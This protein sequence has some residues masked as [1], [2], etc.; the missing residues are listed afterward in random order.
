MKKIA[1]NLKTA[2]YNVIIDAGLLRQA[3]KQIVKALGAVPPFTAVVTSSRIRE[4]WGDELEREH[5]LEHEPDCL[6]AVPPLDTFR[7]NC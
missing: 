1:V 6:L 4:L 5:V 2:P 7:G 3:G